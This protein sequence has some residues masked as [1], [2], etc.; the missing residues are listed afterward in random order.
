MIELQ[1]VSKTYHLKIGDLTA[2][3]NI[4]L[5][6]SPGEIF[7]IIGKSGAGK[8]TLIRCV[9]LLE[10]P[11]S[12]SVIVN[13]HNLTKLKPSHLRTV[14]HEI[15]MIFQH[16]NLLTSRTVYQN[17]ALPL[18]M[19]KFKKSEIKKIILPLL[20]LTGMMNKQDSYPNQLSGGQKQR[21]AIAR[22][23]ATKPKVLLCDEMTSALDPETTSS[24]LKLI[25]SIN[26]QMNLSILLIT[27]QMEVIKTIADRVAVLDHG[28]IVEQQDVVNLFR[29]PQDVITKSLIRSALKLDLP[30]ELSD[31]LVTHPIPSG[32]AIIRISFFGKV[33]EEPII[34]DIIR[35]FEIKVNILQANL[36]LLRD[37][38]MGVMVIALSGSEV[39]KNKAMSYLTKVGLNIEVLGYVKSND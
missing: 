19:Q 12:G 31:R 21:V 25:K 24:I 17:I 7:G 3:S 29:N 2:L 6:V 14:R 15:G 4:S 37:E 23:M 16:F 38:T 27:H 33:A 9:N 18:E 36:E 11:S 22:A 26:Q 35:H 32:D 28:K 34:N 10:V 1:N 5:S 20:E 30:K 8:S 13:G 39:E